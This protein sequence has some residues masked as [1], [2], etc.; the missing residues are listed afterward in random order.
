MNTTTT[1]NEP[2]STTKELTNM[3]SLFLN[4]RKQNAEV[5]KLKDIKYNSLKSIPYRT[6]NS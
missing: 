6:K 4:E 1:K 3:L 2:H 5:V